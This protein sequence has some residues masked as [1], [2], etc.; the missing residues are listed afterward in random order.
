M[1]AKAEASI[2]KEM[3]LVKFLYRQR[4]TSFATMATLDGRQQFIVDKMST[5]IIRE[6][7]DLDESSE[8]DFELDQT[9]VLDIE[10]HSRTIF[11]STN[12]ID[13]RLVSAYQVKHWG[14]D[15]KRNKGKTAPFEAI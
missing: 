3:D 8:D 1:M 10:Q 9:N 14:E 6:S 4:L 15:Y 11:A 2:A 7:S 13:R 5:M 12:D